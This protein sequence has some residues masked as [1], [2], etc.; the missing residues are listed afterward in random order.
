MKRKVSLAIALIGDPEV[1][2]SI[3]ILYALNALIVKN[4]LNN[5]FIG[6]DFR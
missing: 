5:L 6:I 3:I 1:R 4:N 2:K